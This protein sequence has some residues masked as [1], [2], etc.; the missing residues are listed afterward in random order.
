MIKLKSV[1]SEILH[2][3]IIASQQNYIHIFS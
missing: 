3:E 1:L 2:T